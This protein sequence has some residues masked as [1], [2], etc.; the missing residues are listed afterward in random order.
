METKMLNLTPTMA[1]LRETS[2]L[3][4]VFLCY[5]KLIRLFSDAHAKTFQILL[6]ILFTFFFLKKDMGVFLSS[7][8]NI[9]NVFCVY[10]HTNNFSV[11][12]WL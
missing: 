6:R 1:K 7:V 9:L 10:R 8:R 3:Q 4:L 5:V 11:I 12:R 2:N